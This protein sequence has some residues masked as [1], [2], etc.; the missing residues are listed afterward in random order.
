MVQLGGAAVYLSAQEIGI[1]KRESVRTLRTNR[2][3]GCDVISARVFSHQT[4]SRWRSTPPCRSS[5]RCPIPSIPAR[6]WPDFFTL[7][8][9]GIDLSKLRLAWVGDGNKRVSFGAPAG[10]SLCGHVLRRRLSARLR[11]RAWNPGCVSCG[12]RRVR[13]TSDPREAAEGADVIYTDTWISMGQEADRGVGWKPSSAT[14]STRRSLGFASPQA[15]VMHCLPAHR[16]EEITDAMLDGPRSVIFDQG[17][18][19]LHAQKGIIIELLGR[20]P[21]PRPA[22]GRPT[23]TH[24]SAQ[25]ARP[26]I[27]ERQR[28]DIAWKNVQKVVLAYSGGLDT[29]VILRYSSSRPTSARSSPI[30]LTWA[31]GGAD[32]RPRQGA[33]TGASERAC[34][35]PA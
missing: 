26:A 2:R 18:E 21:E 22:P 9:R 3:A 8:E 25:P 15:L 7:W 10:R 1:G 23:G 13:L 11:A 6:R 29:S 4:L 19:R 34:R 17:R 32:P 28:I 24:R 33:R 5:M 30:V 27:G 31:G 14:R 12:R 20:A 35:G 16:G